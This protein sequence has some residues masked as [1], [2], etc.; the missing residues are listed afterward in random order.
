MTLT[1]EDLGDVPDVDSDALDEV[2]ASDG[3]GKSAVLSA[4]G[5]A[6]IRAG[7]TVQNVL[8]QATVLG[9][10]GVPVGAFE[11]RQVADILDP[12]PAARPPS[13]L[14]AVPESTDR[15]VR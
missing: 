10:V 2:L 7:H 4:S 12:Q 15:L 9:L 1:T 11:D 8:L 5:E 14:A 13:R 3:F 6:F